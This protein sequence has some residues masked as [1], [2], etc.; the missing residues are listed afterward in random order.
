MRR[1]HIIHSTLALTPDTHGGDACLPRVRPSDGGGMKLALVAVVVLLMARPSAAQS[2]AQAVQ[3][4]L[5]S[6]R[7][8]EAS[9]FIDTDYARFVN[10]IIRLTEI[11]APP[12]KEDVPW[13]RRTGLVSPSLAMGN[14][15]QKFARIQVPERPKT[16]FNV[17]VVGG[18]TSVNAIPFE[19]WMLVDMRSESKQ[20]LDTLE[21]AFRSVV[22]DAVEEENRTRSTAQ[23]TVTLDVELIGDRPVGETPAASAHVQYAAEVLKAF[24]MR[25]EYRY[26]STDSNIPIA[27]GIP[28]MTIGRG[29]GDRTHSLDEFTSVERGPTVQSVKV[30][31]TMLL[32][33]AG[34]R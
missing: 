8:Q 11:P 23:G 10:E 28:A 21:K 16:T 13:M 31:M 2:P 33:I 25:P 5:Q 30:A 27:M 12:F 15:I 14:A 9:A 32:A 29:P 6:P 20:E 7:M 18:G 4:I 1:I 22:N 19:T 3:S 26:G 17:G 24:G 34:V